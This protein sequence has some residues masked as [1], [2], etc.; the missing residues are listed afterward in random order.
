MDPL[1]LD[2]IATI[3][4]SLGVFVAGG[5]AIWILPWS[6]QAWNER[7]RVAPPDRDGV[8][9]RWIDVSAP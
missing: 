6:E 9:T 5:A 2:L 3:A 1:T 8:S 4:A 7:G